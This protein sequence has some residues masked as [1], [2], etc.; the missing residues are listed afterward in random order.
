MEYLEDIAA[1]EALYGS[2]GAPSLRKVAHRLTPL[3]R[4][5]IMTSRFC[6]LS[7]VGPNGTDGSPRGDD[8]PV[9]TELDEHTLA[10]PDWR[11]NNRLDSLRNIVEDGRVSLMFMVPGSN[12]IVRLNG[13]ARLTTDPDMRSRFERKGR[14]PATVIVIKIG[15]IYTQCARAPMRAGIWSRDDSE[16]LPTVGEILAE[17]S[18]GEEGG[19]DYDAAWS[20]RAA[21]T[22]W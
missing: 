19:A 5:W 11:G 21:K 13:D 20:A 15:E 7:T 8:G 14:Q 2:P 16:G 3:Y 17:A 6:V 1:L 4:K 12:T 10:M 22:M 9:V 18:D